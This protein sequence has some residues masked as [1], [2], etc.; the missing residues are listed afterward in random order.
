MWVN[1][2]LRFV[3]LLY[4]FESWYSHEII[5]HI[6]YKKIHIFYVYTFFLLHPWIKK[7]YNVWVCYIRRRGSP[8]IYLISIVFVYRPILASSTWR[9]HWRFTAMGRSNQSVNAS[10]YHISRV[11]NLRKSYPSDS[12]TALKSLVHIV[13]LN[14]CPA[15]SA[16]PTVVHYLFV[17]LFKHERPPELENTMNIRF[18]IINKVRFIVLI[19]DK[20]WGYLIKK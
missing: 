8:P 12:V 10:T 5:L 20:K 7:L 17:H 14:R 6:F 13:L 2:E 9:Q 18:I 16:L 15:L 19:P 1:G 4:R 3:S 11:Y